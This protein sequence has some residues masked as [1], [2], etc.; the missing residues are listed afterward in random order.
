[1]TGEKR[2]SIMPRRRL[3]K[4]R[5][6]RNYE[7]Q[8]KGIIEGVGEFGIPEIEPVYDIAGVTRWLGFNACRRCVEPE[9]AGVH[10]FID[11]HEFDAVWQKPDRYV[12]MLRRYAVVLSPDFSPYSDFPKAIQVYN[13]YR[14][15][16]CAWY[17]QHNGIKVVPTITWSSPDTLEWAFD[18]EPVG[19]VVAL[20]SVG[21]YDTAEH[22][23]WLVDGCRE[24]FDRLRPRLV[25]WKGKVPEE[26]EGNGRIVKLPE[27]VDKYRRGVV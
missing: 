1:M 10:F 5:L 4:Y 25:L 18:G 2:D 14:K 13:H 6:E 12:E 11:D 16:W 26:Y 15:H 9:R 3:A 8:Q 27:H 22:R 7:N 19:G 20:S 23:A 24:M 21:M 17:W